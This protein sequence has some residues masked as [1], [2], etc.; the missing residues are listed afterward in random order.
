SE[1]ESYE[2]PLDIYNYIRTHIASEFGIKYRRQADDVK[3]AGKATASEN[4]ALL[5]TMLRDKG[6]DAKYVHGQAVISEEQVK[7]MTGASSI[8]KAADVYKEYGIQP[9]KLTSNGAT[10]GLIVEHIWVRAYLPMTDYR[11]AK[12]N[13]G[14][15]AWIGLD[16]YIKSS[17]F[18]QV[19]AL[20][21][22]PYSLQYETRGLNGSREPIVSD[23][24]P[25]SLIP[26][27][28]PTT[29]AA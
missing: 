29:V 18:T 4:A 10:I 9:T 21:L 11:G 28:E 19:E 8:D 25:E 26:E 20:D 7:Y 15:Y 24:I 6:Y 13:Q 5:V 1:D 14:E 17:D 12:D 22:L 2:T 3:T 23:D 27:E 16:A